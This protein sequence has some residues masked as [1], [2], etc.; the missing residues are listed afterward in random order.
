MRVPVVF[1]NS[2]PFMWLRPPLPDEP[3][4]YLSG[5]A[6]SSCRNPARSCAGSAGFTTST[7]GTSA[8]LLMGAKSLTGS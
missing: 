8:R 3:K 6:F 5:L 4:A 7:L 2:S 1:R